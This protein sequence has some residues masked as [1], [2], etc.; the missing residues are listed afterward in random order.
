M[1][2]PDANDLACF[3]EAFLD[4]MPDSAQIRRSTSTPDGLG[5]STS[6]PATVAT[7]ACSVEPSGNTS[8]E[9]AI[10]ERIQATVL[11]TI[12]VPVGT[13]VQADDDIL[14]AGK[15]YHVVAPLSG[16]SFELTRR[17]ACIEVL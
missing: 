16:S 12:T 5:G 15:T 3:R 10:A 2:G 6:T 4:L 8:E 17:V 11:W 1:S 9:R 13:S 7:V 14:I